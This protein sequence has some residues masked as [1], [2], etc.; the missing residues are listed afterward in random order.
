[1][2]GF[3]I[4]DVDEC[5]LCRVNL[6]GFFRMFIQ[7]SNGCDMHQPYLL[8]EN[9]EQDFLSVNRERLEDKLW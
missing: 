3:N 5:R 4:A 7:P 6:A 2:P 1:M 9:A 8:Q